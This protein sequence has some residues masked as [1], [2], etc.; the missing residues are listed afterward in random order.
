MLKISKI[1]LLIVTCIYLSSISA[2]VQCIST[3]LSLQKCLDEERETVAGLTVS[4]ADQR[5]QASLM[6]RELATGAEDLAQLKRNE[7]TSTQFL[8][9]Q[10]HSL[11]V[12]RGVDLVAGVL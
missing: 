8:E 7:I 6:K 5:D 12:C 3:Y 1:S 2:T 11:N 9:S 10:I 4:L